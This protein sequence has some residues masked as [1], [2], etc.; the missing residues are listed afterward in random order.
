MKRAM[1]WL[2]VLLVGALLG[3]AWVA[4]EIYLHMQGGMVWESVL[5]VTALLVGVSFYLDRES[6]H[7]DEAIRRVNHERNVWKRRMLWVCPLLMVMLLGCP[8]LFQGRYVPPK[9]EVGMTIEEVEDVV[10]PVGRWK[11]PEPMAE[12]PIT[13]SWR[14]KKGVVLITFLRERVVHVDG[15]FTPVRQPSFCQRVRDWIGW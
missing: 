6:R 12:R 15:E 8:C 1:L 2:Y 5:L 7:V 11:L 14:G 9:I 13:I 4:P 3:C 10:G